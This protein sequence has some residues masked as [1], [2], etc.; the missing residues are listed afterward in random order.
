M[1]TLIKQS[2]WSCILFGTVI[3]TWLVS[4]D[5]MTNIYLACLSFPTISDDSHLHFYHTAAIIT[6]ENND[7]HSR[8]RISITSI[9]YRLNGKVSTAG[10]SIE[11]GRMDCHTMVYNS[12]V[13]HLVQ[14][15][16]WPCLIRTNWLFISLSH[17]SR[18]RPVQ[19]MRTLVVSLLHH[20]S[21][22][23]GNYVLAA[24]AQA[25]WRSGTRPFHTGQHQILLCRQESR[26]GVEGSWDK[27]WFVW[28]WWLT[29]RC[30]NYKR[31]KALRSST[32][33]SN[34]ETPYMGRW[35]VTIQ[36][37][38][39]TRQD[40]CSFSRSLRSLAHQSTAAQFI[41][42]Q[43]DSFISRNLKREKFL[44]FFVCDSILENGH[45][46]LF[47]FSGLSFTNM[48]SSL[49]CQEIFFC[50]IQLSSRCMF[51]YWALHAFYVRSLFLFDRS[52]R[53]KIGSLD[54]QIVKAHRHTQ[55]ARRLS[56][57]SVRKKSEIP[58]DCSVPV[59]P[60]LPP[61]SW[62]SEVGNRSCSGSTKLVLANG[63]ISHPRSSN[64]FPFPFPC[65][66]PG[67]PP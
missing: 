34:D 31:Y 59:R 61:I 47:F 10:S 44:M 24:A 60:H 38:M 39:R 67:W 13:T 6:T 2:D 56:I 37:S 5:A 62:R 19:A 40:R 51:S 12:L 48:S 21:C 33:A 7:H 3:S 4:Y 58:N 50:Q 52:L 16:P 54:F 45:T 57:L 43:V 17:L 55:G 53:N 63:L 41:L 35:H 15:Q 8:S 1:A 25:T 22:Q 49:P 30:V 18:R 42:H 9:L 11:V 20:P 36:I 66:G 65:L 29:S 46:S 26:P 23:D 14:V 32:I 64:F 28:G 27:G